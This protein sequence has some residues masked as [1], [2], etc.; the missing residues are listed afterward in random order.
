MGVTRVSAPP[1][2]EIRKLG[3]LFLPAVSK[4]PAK[5]PIYAVVEQPG[6][7]A[8]LAFQPFEVRAPGFSSL[9]A[10]HKP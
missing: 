10:G 5:A 4:L 9:Q 2:Y 8:V 7:M 1:F 3:A 6:A